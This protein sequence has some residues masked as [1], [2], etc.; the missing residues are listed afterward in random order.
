MIF[1]RPFT[2]LPRRFAMPPNGK[3]ISVR[4][5]LVLPHRQTMFLLGFALFPLGFALLFMRKMLL[6][7][8]GLEFLAGI[9]R[10]V[11]GK[12]VFRSSGVVPVVRQALLLTG[13]TL[14]LASE[15]TRQDTVSVDPAGDS[16]LL[17]GAA[18]S[19]SGLVAFSGPRKRAGVR[20][21]PGRISVIWPRIF[22][23]VNTHDISCEDKLVPSRVRR[24][25]MSRSVK[26][27]VIRRIAQST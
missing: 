15:A 1:G 27:S 18:W 13:P 11:A 24:V 5:F 17:A 7:M 3:T 12:T 26:S 20:P 22:N 14:P 19:A 10:S 2:M 23:R 25:W 6:A 8:R 9:A 21:V 4:R 16:M